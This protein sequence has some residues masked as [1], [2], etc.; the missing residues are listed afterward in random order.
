MYDSS[1]PS[2]R[3]TDESKPL[4]KIYP[5][6]SFNSTDIS[7]VIDEDILSEIKPIL[8]VYNAQ[9]G[10]LTT[11][12]LNNK[13]QAVSIPDYIGLLFVTIENEG[14]IVHKQKLIRI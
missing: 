10:L 7:V 14:Q 8:R 5:N 6:P 4:V 2:P 11:Q 9:G 13:V 1:S 3:A 12:Y